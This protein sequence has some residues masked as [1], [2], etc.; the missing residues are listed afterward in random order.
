MLIKV[1]VRPAREGLFQIE[2]TNDHG[3]V[4]TFVLYGY[5]VQEALAKAHAMRR[6]SGLCVNCGRGPGDISPCEACGFESK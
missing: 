1:E 3:T 2:A 6:E 5:T 4:E